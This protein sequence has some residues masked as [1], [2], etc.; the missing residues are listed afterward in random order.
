[1]TEIKNKGGRPKGKLD[2]SPRK[3]RTIEELEKN[4]TM[5][6]SDDFPRVSLI[7]RP[8]GAKDKTLRKNSVFLKEKWKEANILT[9]NLD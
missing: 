1:M 5:E 4:K 6:P 8:H 2:S 9:H 7:G 3:R